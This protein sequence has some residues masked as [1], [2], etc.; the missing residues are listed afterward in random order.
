MSNNLTAQ[1]VLEQPNV[2]VIPNNYFNKIGFI[3]GT[4]ECLL[5]LFKEQLDD[6]QQK[7]VNT[8][9]EY[10]QEISETDFFPLAALTA[11][12]KQQGEEPWV[13]N[14]DQHLNYIIKTINNRIEQLE[15]CKEGHT[16]EEIDAIS[17]RQS[18]LDNIRQL[19][20]Q[21]P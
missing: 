14:S 4:I 15:A 10:Y 2:R 9:L 16:P 1:Q 3:G 11:H 19:A 6:K 18:E 7:A 21:S 5:L 20:Q 12:P 8:A 17:L 13:L